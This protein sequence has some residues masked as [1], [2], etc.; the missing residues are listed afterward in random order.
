MNMKALNKIKNLSIILTITLL[1]VSLSSI[2]VFADDLK[3][4]GNDLGLVVTPGDTNLFDES[5][6]SPGDCKEATITIENNYTSPFEL[7]L[8]VNREQES[9]IGEPDLLEEIMATISYK[10][11]VFYQ[12]PMSAFALAPDG[13]GLGNFN[14]GDSREIKIEVCLPGP[15]TGNE[16]MGLSASNQWIF[17]AQGEDVVIIEDEDPPLG[18]IE[19]ETVIIEDE[20]TPIGKAKIPQTGGIPP[21]LFFLAGATIVTAGI[22]LKKKGE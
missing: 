13:V 6:L 5:N 1:L 18:P 12:G 11:D 21:E 2:S 7:Y 14:P 20:E 8:K 16:F 3:V 17:T 22:V 4:V 9:L 15:E 10:D 19:E